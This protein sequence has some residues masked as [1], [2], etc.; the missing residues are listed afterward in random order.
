MTIPT[1]RIGLIGAGGIA[2][3]HVSGYRRNPATVRF[4][5]VADPIRENALKRAEG[6][7][8]VIY[9]DYSRMLA[10]AD[11]DAVDICL[12]H[13][14]HRG[15]ILAAA[16]AGKH[17]LC[18]KPL[19]LDMREAADVAAA[20]AASGITVMCAHNQLFLPAVA[21]AKELI[22]S[23]RLGR[24]YQVRTTDCFFSD[25]TPESIGWRAQ[26]RTS[27]GGELLDTG[28]HPTYLLLYLAGGN[29]VDV[30]AMLS[31]HRL[32]FLEGEDS[33]QVLVRFDNGMIGSISTSWAFQS[34]A[35]T[36]RFSVVCERGS[37]TSDGASLS[38][39]LRGSD[40]VTVDFE[41]V[42]EFEAEI[43]HFA[44]SIRFGTRP[45]HNHEDGIRVLGIILAAYESARTRS[46][47]PVLTTD[48]ISSAA[49]LAT[50]R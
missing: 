12:P 17:V 8:A 50:Q 42:H 46:V 25:F 2:G 40:P 38:Y 28:Y 23:G 37:L 26:R 29:P 4:G 43:A 41:P 24:I 10:E 18:E 1:V 22:D 6:T 45:I 9:D 33:A 21:A 30:T 47:A 27:G 31:T 34:A 32:D 13:H 11:I 48:E 35:N 5:A 19:C 3:A 7:D 39:T 14:L 49:D 15:A 36:E 20:V 16:D 44:D